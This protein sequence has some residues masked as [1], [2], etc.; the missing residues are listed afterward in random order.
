MP[1]SG[2]RASGQK[3]TLEPWRTV[4]FPFP[5]RRPYHASPKLTFP[6]A[7]SYAWML[8][9][10][11]FNKKLGWGDNGHTDIPFEGDPTKRSLVSARDDG[12][13]TLY[14]LDEVAGDDNN[15]IDGDQLPA[16]ALVTIPTCQNEATCEYTADDDLPPDATPAPPPPPANGP[17]RCNGLAS[18]KYIPAPSLDDKIAGFCSGLQAQGIQD[19]NSGSYGR[20]FNAGTREEVELFVDWP[21][22]QKLD[23]QPCA[24]TMGEI[25]ASCDG[26]DPTNPRNWKGGGSKVVGG[27][28]FRINPRVTRSSPPAKFC[29]VCK[30]PAHRMISRLRC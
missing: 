27:G 28:N 25:S 23:F 13:P 16:T 20:V 2:R 17:L 12:P 1:T 6:L 3:S 24:A 29:P 7:D 10:N 21:P 14:P 18:H 30:L 22:G 8:T 4:C 19:T 5:C 15:I 11:Y 26:N 9:N